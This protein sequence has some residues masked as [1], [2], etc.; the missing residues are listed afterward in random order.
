M[1]GDTDLDERAAADRLDWVL[2]TLAEPGAV[3]IADLDAIYDT[4]GWRGWSLEEERD[5]LRADDWLVRPFAVTD[6]DTVKPWQ[7]SAVLVG[8]DDKRWALTC[9][10][11][12]EPPH[13]ITGCR[14]VQAPPEGTT[15]RDATP[16]DALELAALERRSPLRL[17]NETFLTF[18]RGDDYFASAR[19]M[20]DVTIYVAEVDGRIAGAYWGAQQRVLVDGEP[21]KL[22]LEHHVR[23][24]PET[25]RGGVFWALVVYG[26]DTYAR[27]A[28]SIA[29]YVSPE[30]EAV[31]KFV[32]DVPAWSVRPVRALIPVAGA[33]APAPPTTRATPADA[34]TVVE[35]L[36]ACHAGEELYVPYTVES[37][38]ARLDRSPE[39]Y[40]WSDLRLADGVVVG[41]GGLPVDVTRA[42]HGERRVTR[43]ASVLDHGF[44]P[45]CDDAYAAALQA[46]A[47]ELATTGV[48]HLAAFTSPGSRTEPGL[49]RLP[50]EI[51]PYDFWAFDIPEP[52]ELAARGFYVDPVYF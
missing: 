51:E 15:V 25:R 9:W 16:E 10:V 7:A 3:T 33:G 50:A 44:A 32:V 14:N 24:D 8:A 23:I 4:T 47:A 5:R 40:S 20:E 42:Q 30:N 17:A 35:I 22:F 37:L 43:R 2:A 29:F 13:R 39:Q 45:G 6:V 26:R 27:S 49:A 41:V 34:A 19:L 38:T 12:E 1:L 11:S 36:N 48:T 21:K 46:T 18:D 52:P 28:D 31:R